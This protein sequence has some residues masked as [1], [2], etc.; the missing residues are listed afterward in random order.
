MAHGD[1]PD[2]NKE[3]FKY[4]LERIHIVEVALKEEDGIDISEKTKTWRG[5][6]NF[7]EAMNSIKKKWILTFFIGNVPKVDLLFQMFQMNFC[8]LGSIF[9]MTHL[10]SLYTWGRRWEKSWALLDFPW[11]WWSVILV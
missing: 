6:N 1:L 10:E 2:I 8:L 5:Y 9:Y 4:L 7:I 3:M 11:W